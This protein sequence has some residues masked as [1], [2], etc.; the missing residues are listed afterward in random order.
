MYINICINIYVY[1]NET[2]VVT[3]GEVTSVFFP[4]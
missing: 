1:K 2:L 4:I 3:L